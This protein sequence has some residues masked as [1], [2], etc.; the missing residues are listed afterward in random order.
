VYAPRADGAR[1]ARMSR[2]TAFL[3]DTALRSD[4]IFWA[5]SKLARKTFIRSV[6]GTP[7]EVAARASAE[8]QARLRRVLQDILPMRP[9]R[10]GLLND[11]AVI[12]SQRRSELEKITAP[13]LAISTAD[14]LYGT[15]EGARYTAA[16]VPHARFVGY[17]SGGHMLVG[18]DADAA[19][20]IYAFLNSA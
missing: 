1:P 2:R 14:D 13:T 8:E 4:F 7:P 10:L 19:A 16:H 20:E 3:F 15:F 17:P 6:L 12:S 18:H 5:G 9:R 11:A